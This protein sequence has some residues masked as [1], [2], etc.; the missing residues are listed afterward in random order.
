MEISNKNYTIEII[1]KD[2]DSLK[3]SKGSVS[4]KLINESKELH[5]VNILEYLMGVLLEKLYKNA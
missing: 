3:I 4:S 2:E 1:I 5:N